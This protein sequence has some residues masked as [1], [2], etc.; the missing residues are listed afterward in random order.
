MQIPHT[1]QGGEFLA[2][3]ISW[4]DAFIFPN[5]AVG[6]MVYF[7]WHCPKKIEM[8]DNCPH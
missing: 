5:T 6:L 1:F 2:C 4:C 8:R 7:V 3:T